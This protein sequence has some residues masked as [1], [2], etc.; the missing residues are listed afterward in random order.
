MTP[1]PKG[2]PKT[3]ITGRPVS[4]PRKHAAG[5]G[6]SAWKIEVE[7]DLWGRVVGIN[8]ARAGRFE[9]LALTAQVVRQSLARIM[10]QA[11]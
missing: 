9:T 6:F 4:V 11:K 8:I 2:A 10:A 3:V 5:G 1:E 7:V